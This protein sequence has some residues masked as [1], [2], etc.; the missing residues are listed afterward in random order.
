MQDVRQSIWKKTAILRFRLVTYRACSNEA[1]TA[2]QVVVGGAVVTAHLC[3]LLG[4]L[5]HT[6]TAELQALYALLVPL[7]AH[8]EGAGN[9]SHDW[10]P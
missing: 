2:S 5:A 1:K 4:A 6:T 7:G 3:S 8:A 9:C 10:L